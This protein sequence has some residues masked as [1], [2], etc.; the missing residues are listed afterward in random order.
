MK[1]PNDLPVNIFIELTTRC[2]IW[3]LKC[4]NRI[5][6]GKGSD[7]NFSLLNKILFNE[8]ENYSGMISIGTGESLLVLKHLFLIDEWLK[9]SKK[10]K[11]RI[12]TN[13]ILLKSIPEKLL[14]NEQI[15]W[16]ITIDGMNQQN[17]EGFQKNI[18]INNILDNI[19]YITNNYPKT[20]IYI[21]FTLTNTNFCELPNLINFISS[22]KLKSVYITPLRIFEYCN[23]EKLINFYFDITNED[24]IRL[25]NQ[26][27][28][29]ADKLGIKLIL[30]H[31]KFKIPC[32][33]PQPIIHLNGKISFCNEHEGEFL[34]FKNDILNN[35]LLLK[36]SLPI[37]WCKKC[38]IRSKS[39]IVEPLPV[40]L[41]K[42]CK[43]NLE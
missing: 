26:Y 38:E 40:N 17:I 2:N 12:L 29:T 6:Y 23:V 7:I 4:P 13:G 37:N 22:I 35:W 14:F 1:N 9:K 21:N 36:K 8:L 3:C 11:A 10:R 32:G 30:P 27:V 42:K 19:I 39:G 41:K 34:N 18:I 20:K 31:F 33:T 28:D 5:A 25:L 15:T 16:G 24:N 43:K